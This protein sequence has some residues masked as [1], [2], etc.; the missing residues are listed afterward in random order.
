M[1]YSWMPNLSAVPFARCPIYGVK[2]VRDRVH[3]TCQRTGPFAARH[4][5]RW[6]LGRVGNV[7]CNDAVAAIGPLWSVPCH[8]INPQIQPSCIGSGWAPHRRESSPPLPAFASCL[9]RGL[10][11]QPESG[12]KPRPVDRSSQAPSQRRESSSRRRVRQPRRQPR[13]LSARPPTAQ[14]RPSQLLTR[15]RSNRLAKHQSL[16]RR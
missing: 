11:R 3:L 10:P 12:P 8:A 15:Q 13:P 2:M 14:D 5:C 6:H 4:A 16:R 1:S 9:R 7:R